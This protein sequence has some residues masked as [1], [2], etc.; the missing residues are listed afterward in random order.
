M[1]APKAERILTTILTGYLG[2]GKTSAVNHLLSANTGKRIAV[3]VNDFGA[4]NI[5][6]SLIINQNDQT[7]SLENGCVC[8]SLSDGLSQALSDQVARNDRPNMIVIEASGVADPIRLAKHVS[9]WPGI[10]LH[11]LITMVDVSTIQSRA[12]DKYVGSL[13]KSQIMAAQKLIANKTDLLS[14]VDLPAAIG[15]LKSTNQLAECIGATHG[16]FDLSIYWENSTSHVFQ[17]L[18]P[19]LE[20]SESIRSEVLTPVGRIEVS[21]LSALANSSFSVVQRLKGYIVDAS[22]GKQYLV[23]YS[24][25]NLSLS[26][27]ENCKIKTGNQLVIITTGHKGEHEALLKDFSDLGLIISSQQLS[28]LI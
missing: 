17:S 4:I 19:F 24:G 2:S 15:W 18:A 7:I 28:S 26:E 5:D 11:N 23:Q 22:S 20:K 10:E 3:L 13:V 21:A 25:G 12:S 9:G 14:S 27:I 6:A 16:K 1:L 8:C